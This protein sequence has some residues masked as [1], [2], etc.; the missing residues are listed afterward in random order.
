MRKKITQTGFTMVEM[1]IT[2]GLTAFMGAMVYSV[3]QWA[4][5]ETQAET[6]SLLGLTQRFGSTKVLARDIANSTPSLN[7]INIKD[8]AGRPFF[9]FPSRE[10]C[11]N[12]NC[13]RVFTLKINSGQ[14]VSEPLFFIVVS[15]LTSEILNLGVDSRMTFDTS[16]NFLGVNW[17]KSSNPSL[18]I[19]KSVE[20]SSPWIKGRLFMLESVNHFYDCESSTQLFTPPVSSNCD[21]KSPPSGV[22]NF[23]AARPL[24]MIGTVNGDEKDMTFTPVKNRSDLLKTKYQLCRPGVTSSCV[25][26][27]NFSGGLDIKSSKKLFENMPFIPGSDNQASLVPV[28]LIR[29]HLERPTPNSPDSKIVL[30]RSSATIVGGELSFERAHVLM[31][32]IQSVVFTRPNISN[33][34][35]DYR[36]IKGRN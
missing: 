18:G 11:L 7:Y 15:G 28:E 14:V 21:V 17:E 35:I 22:V 10:Y 6:E 26:T 34:T 3:V 20:P 31:T 9:V 1:M 30:M 13:E 36:F 29:Y 23:S 4:D 2:L 33:S 8:D 32:G 19:S 12:A 5:K 16:A 27:S 25:V 24:K